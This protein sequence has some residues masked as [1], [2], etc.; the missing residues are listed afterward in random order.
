MKKIKWSNV[1]KAI[2]LLACV[3]TVL[4]DAYYLI[5]KL[6]TLTMYGLATHLLAWFIGSNVYDDLEEQWVS[7]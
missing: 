2:I 5:F 4:G 7:I 6:G 1:L 3:L